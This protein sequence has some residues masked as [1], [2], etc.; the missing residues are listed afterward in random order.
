MPPVEQAGAVAVRGDGPSA[1]LLLVTA[2]KN[3][4]DWIFPKGHLEPHETPADA[5]V[6]EL[7]EEA[8]VVGEVI[9][10][11]GISHFRSGDE[12][13]RVTYFLVRVVGFAPGAEPRQSAWRPFREARAL[14]TFDDARSLL[15]RAERLMNPH[16]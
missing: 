5:A 4:R 2:K 12:D 8:G 13:A 15:D 10:P 16:P 1:E 7:L 6:R 14:L 3:P 9:R 11:L